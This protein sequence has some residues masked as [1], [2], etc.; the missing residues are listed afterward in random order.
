MATTRLEVRLEEKI[1]AKAEKASVL[2]GAKN[3]TSYVVNLMEKDATKVIA[4]HESMTIKD[5]IF[6]RF[7]DAC[8]K[9]RKPNKA[10]L[11][12]ATFTKN[13]GIK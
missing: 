8:A 10:L 4:K 11:D 1:K 5:D 9:A 3:L 2:L 13:Q 7:M 12:A 6:D